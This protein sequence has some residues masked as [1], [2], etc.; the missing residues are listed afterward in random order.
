MKGCQIMYHTAFWAIQPSG[1][2]RH[3]YHPFGMKLL[4]DLP[5][6]MTVPHAKF[7]V[8]HRSVREVVPMR[9]LGCQTMYPYGTLEGHKVQSCAGWRCGLL[10]RLVNVFSHPCTC[11]W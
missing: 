1:H 11:M 7:H 5:H 4:H 10:I 9:V 3:G 8:P 2:H 6:Y